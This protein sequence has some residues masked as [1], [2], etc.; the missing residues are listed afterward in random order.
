M[1]K[2]RLSLEVA[3]RRVCLFYRKEEL[4]HGHQQNLKSQKVRLRVAPRG[5]KKSDPKFAILGNFKA[6]LEHF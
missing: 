3:Y 1:N 6:A 4:S 2:R 5:P